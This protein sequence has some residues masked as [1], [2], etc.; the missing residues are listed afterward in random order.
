MGKHKD[1][2]EDILEERRQ[3]S[4]LAYIFRSQTH[5]PHYKYNKDRDPKQIKQHVLESD[6]VRYRIEMVCTV[7]LT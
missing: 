1:G 5:V 4:D 2:F 7:R 6:R 3:T